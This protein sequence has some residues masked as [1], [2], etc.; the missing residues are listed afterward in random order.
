MSVD[1]IQKVHGAN[2][3]CSKTGTMYDF[4]TM[5]GVLNIDSIGDHDIHRGRRI[6]WDRAFN[7]TGNC[8]PDL[9]VDLF[10]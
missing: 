7:G 9:V 5:G 3:L 10:S 1:A 2:S 6:P 8:F 4:I